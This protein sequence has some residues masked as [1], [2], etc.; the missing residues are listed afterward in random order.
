MTGVEIIAAER[1]RQI[2]VEGFTPAHDDQWTGGALAEA[3]MAYAMPAKTIV[4]NVG[5]DDKF[6]IYLRINRNF[7]FPDDW[8]T[9][10]WKPT[11]KNRIRELAKA[12]ALIAAEIDRI[13]RGL[14]LDDVHPADGEIE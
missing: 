8:G 11:D 14:N 10:W 9:E 13:L 5:G 4:V 1:T 7:F 3:A 12:G 6:S 2:E